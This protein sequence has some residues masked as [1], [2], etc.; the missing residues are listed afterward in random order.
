MTFGSVTLLSGYQ[1]AM[2]GAIGPLVAAAS[3]KYGKRLWFL[4]SAVFLFAGTIWCAMATSY[5]SMVGGRLVQG[6][7][8]AI[9]ESVTFTLIGDLYFVHQRGSRMAIYIV[10]Q[11]ALVLLPSLL[12]GVVSV[13]LG[14]RWCFWLLVIFL[15]IGTIFLALF[16][17][18]TAYN[19]NQIYDLDVASRDVS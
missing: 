15:G 14:W 3:H 11:V 6:V 17:W 13:H 2:V 1:L 12:T 10:A 16:G 8:T 18:E 7:G 9:Y 4:T 5:D 19:R